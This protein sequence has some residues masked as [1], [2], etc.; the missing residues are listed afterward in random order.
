M[1]D[2]QLYF[3]SEIA[4]SKACD[5]I[6]EFNN[7]VSQCSGKPEEL[8]AVLF[9]S[10]GAPFATFSF[11]R[12]ANVPFSEKQY[13]SRSSLQTSKHVQLIEAFEGMFS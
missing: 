6:S 11:E 10:D 4:L 12:R 8:W 5:K 1:Y 2:S 3:T 9:Q 13:Y 7:L